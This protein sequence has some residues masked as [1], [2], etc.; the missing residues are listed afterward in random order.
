MGFTQ[1]IEVLTEKLELSVVRRF[2]KN[3]L[4]LSVTAG[5]ADEG[6]ERGCYETQFRRCEEDAKCSLAVS[7]FRIARLVAVFDQA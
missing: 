4:N 6:V 2:R 7:G 3:Y 1:R 5:R